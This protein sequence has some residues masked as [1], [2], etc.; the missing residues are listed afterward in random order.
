MV[1]ENRIR[2]NASPLVEN[3]L[4]ELKNEIM[5]NTIS[6]RSPQGGDSPS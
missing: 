1:N 4:N 5:N 6:Y 3:K 2:M